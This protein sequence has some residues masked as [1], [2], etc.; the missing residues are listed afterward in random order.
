MKYIL[1]ES[2]IP[3][4]KERIMAQS[5]LKIHQIYPNIIE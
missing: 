4:L 2:T 3:N 5:D 1:D